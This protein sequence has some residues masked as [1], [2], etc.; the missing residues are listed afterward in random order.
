MFLIEHL[1]AA[2]RAEMVAITNVHYHQKFDFIT[3]TFVL[4]FCT[5]INFWYI[6]QGMCFTL[7]ERQ[8]LGLQGL[9]PPNIITQD[10]QVYFVMQNF[11][12]W[13]NDLDRFI[14]MM[15]LQVEFL[16]HVQVIVSSSLMS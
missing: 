7:R 11:Y 3:H 14:Y 16:K 1:S 5:V 12:R 15:S 4:F 9:L 10:Q 8:L 2:L 6:F 13:D